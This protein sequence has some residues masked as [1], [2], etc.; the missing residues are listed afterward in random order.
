MPTNQL[1][2]V[3]TGASSGIGEATARKL[4]TAGYQV[5]LGARRID[6]LKQ[7]ATEINA[8]AL[9]LDVTDETSVSNFVNQLETVDVLVNNAGLALSKDEI[10]NA[11]I[12]EWET[13][14]KTNV[15]GNLLMDKAIIPKML[16]AEKGHIINVTSIS[17][18]S[19]YIGGAGYT[20]S[21]HAQGALHETL[22]ME[23]LGTPIRL[24]EICP[25][26]VETEFSVQRFHG[27]QNAADKVYEGFKPLTGDNIADSIVFAVQ[28]PANVNIDKIVI[29]PI[30]QNIG[31][32]NRTN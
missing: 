8:I 30:N 13:M 20:S 31:D 21:K 3:I 17:A 22:R 19:T 14:W 32:F 28:Q 29:Q 6:K 12:S 25:G 16:R 1:V 26:A 10:V 23:L 27:D 9:P 7:I 15:M 5:I 11:K 4:A 24:T 18:F 2:A